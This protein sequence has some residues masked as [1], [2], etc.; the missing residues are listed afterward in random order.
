MMSFIITTIV[1]MFNGFKKE[2]WHMLGSRAIAVRT[3]ALLE[4]TIAHY[5]T[6]EGAIL[7]TIPIH[8]FVVMSISTIISIAVVV[9]F[10]PDCY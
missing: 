6:P 2:Q 1:L 10:S 8:I 7:P 3:S 4:A 5:F 9:P